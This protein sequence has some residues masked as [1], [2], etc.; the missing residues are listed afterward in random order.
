MKNWRNLPIGN[1]Y[2]IYEENGEQ[3]GQQFRTGTGPVDILGLNKDKTDFLVLE[4]KRD[5]AS[6]VVVGQTLRYMGWVQ[7]HLCSPAQSVN[8][9]IIAHAQDEKLQYALNQVPNIR[10]M[11]YEVDFRLVG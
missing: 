8:G 6:D 9:C 2:D 5:R 10:F 3:V 7:E 1:Q 11:K 4:L